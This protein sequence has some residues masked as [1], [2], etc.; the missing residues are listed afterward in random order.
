MRRKGFIHTSCNALYRFAV[1]SQKSSGSCAQLVYA[2]CTCCASMSSTAFEEIA[3]KDSCNVFRGSVSFIKRV[4]KQK[5]SQRAD[6]FSL[7]PKALRIWFFDTYLDAFSLHCLKRAYSHDPTLFH[8]VGVDE[9]Q[10]VNYVSCNAFEWFDITKV[11]Q[12]LM[13][14]VRKLPHA[15]ITARANAIDFDICVFCFD[16][17]TS[18]SSCSDRYFQIQ[19]E[20]I[21]GCEPDTND[22]ESPDTVPFCDACYTKLLPSGKL[23]GNST[24]KIHG[25][26]FYIDSCYRMND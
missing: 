15:T 14:P 2:F 24:I 5:M 6:F 22:E 9:L 18:K 16:F 8:K 23:D 7:L 21:C 4:L 20:W 25:H 19:G 11:A 3:P 1:Q 13:F 12:F 26:K 17:C 10:Y